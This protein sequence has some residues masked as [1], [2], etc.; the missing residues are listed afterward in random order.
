MVLLEWT[1]TWEGFVWIPCNLQSYAMVLLS[2]GALVCLPVQSIKTL[3]AIFPCLCFS[4]VMTLNASLHQQK[5]R[6]DKLQLCETLPF[7][8]KSLWERASLQTNLL[9]LGPMMFWSTTITISFCFSLSTIVIMHCRVVWTG[10]LHEITGRLPT[11][12]ESRVEPFF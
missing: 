12:V 8:Y 3:C 1:L 6:K 7:F 9:G 5:Y 10:R 11:F 2:G 4:A